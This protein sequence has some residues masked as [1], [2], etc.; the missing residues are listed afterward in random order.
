MLWYRL[1]FLVLLVFLLSIQ[2]CSDLLGTPHPDAPPSTE[3]IASTDAA[4][5]STTETNTTEETTPETISP[6]ER[7]QTPDEPPPEVTQ[8]PPTETE[9]PPPTHDVLSPDRSR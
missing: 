7:P 4:E 5:A 2:G 8:E 3:T 1:C 9:P 6:P